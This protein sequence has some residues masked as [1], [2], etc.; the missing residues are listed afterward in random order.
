MDY[1]Y[2]SQG[3]LV[4]KTYIQFLKNYYMKIPSWHFIFYFKHK[5]LQILTNKNLYYKILTQFQWYKIWVY[6]LRLI[7]MIV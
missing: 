7:S 6:Q 3:E 1:W 4:N 5:R 2:N